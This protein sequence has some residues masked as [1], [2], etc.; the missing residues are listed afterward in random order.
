MLKSTNIRKLAVCA[1]LAALL[2]AVNVFAAAKETPSR[3]T[4]RDLELRAALAVRVNLDYALPADLAEIVSFLNEHIAA[5]ANFTNALMLDG[6]VVATDPRQVKITMED[7]RVGTAL[8]LILT[9][10]TTAAEEAANNDLT[11]VPSFEHAVI[12]ITQT[13]RARRLNARRKELRI[14]EVRDLLAQF[15]VGGQGGAGGNM[16]GNYIAPGQNSPNT[17]GTAMPMIGR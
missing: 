8:A 5:K 16:S 11:L 6:R 14:Y 2:G 13:D 15:P 4:P 1:V 12:Y 9:E 17:Q 7:V 3:T 10:A